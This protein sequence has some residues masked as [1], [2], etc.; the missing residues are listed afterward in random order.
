MV[1]LSLREVQIAELEILRVFNALC[2]EIGV[3]Y[4][5]GG[6]TLLGAV[7]HGG[8]IPWDDDVDVLM[9]RPAFEKFLDIAPCRFEKSRFKLVGCGSDGLALQDCPL[10][11]LVDTTV[12]AKPKMESGDS[13][14]WIDIIPVDGLP[15]SFDDLS[16]CYARAKL[17]RH[18]IMWANADVAS[19]S[20]LPERL[21]V[22]IEK[23]LF[24]NRLIERKACLM[25]NSL[26]RS[27]D[28]SSSD[29]VG[30]ITWG[31]YGVNEALP[32]TG[33]ERTVLLRFEGDEYPCMSCYETYLGN[34][35]GDY[36]K[37]P[38]V[39]SRQSHAVRAWRAAQK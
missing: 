1:E 9:S 32:R 26:A 24:G 17:L 11:K 27:F 20:F 36:M 6:G 39:E 38:P 3:T 33:F 23:V 21:L 7:R 16:A 22:A 4:S 19:I 29:T 12:K 5:L 2:N 30:A 34:V 28:Y 14:L 35:Y 10:V 13:F 25:L 8:F 31:L 15:E 37:L 18:P